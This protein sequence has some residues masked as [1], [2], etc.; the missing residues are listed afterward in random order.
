MRA[1]AGMTLVAVAVAASA[2]CGTSA[3]RPRPAA[4]AALT[5]E[6]RAQ[7]A[8]VGVRARIGTDV[9]RA[10]GTV[11]DADAGL[12]VTSAH[13]VWGATSLKLD[14]A[15]G[16]L[17]GRV[18]ARAPCDDLA[19]LETQPRLPGL[20]T[21]PSGGAAPPAAAV[22]RRWAL[23]TPGGGGLIRVPVRRQRTDHGRRLDG[24]L[25]PL[26]ASLRLDLPL[27]PE[28]TGGPVLDR[29][30]RVVAVA[31]VATR[32]ALHA[33][34]APWSAVRARLDELRPGPRRLYVGW[35]EQY[36]CAG[37]LDAF[38]QAHHA[39]FAAAAARLAAPVAV[40]RLPGTEALDR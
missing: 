18:V 32:P 40:S 27:A 9:V 34:A 33:A 21:L 22:T 37:E 29:A 16:V 3:R 20:A 24:R 26:A 25:P 35:R 6:Q 17:H 39:G 36:R 2:A 23:A 8:I 14:T 5:A 15:L 11:V 28:A 19:L 30:G 10:T 7:L 13:A 38:A 31:V 1:L 4:P 12:V